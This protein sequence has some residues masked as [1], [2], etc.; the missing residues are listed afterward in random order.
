MHYVIPAKAGIQSIKKS[1]TQWDIAF[2]P[3]LARYAELYD[4]L[5]SG[6]R[7]ND[8]GAW[9][10]VMNYGKINKRNLS[11]L[12]CSPM[13]APQVDHDNTSGEKPRRMVFSVTTRG[14]RNC[15][16]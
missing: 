8:D 14:S 11:L 7:R 3:S 2:A 13:A 5:D 9:R 10:F 4:G 6:L 12:I 16:R 1:P 15:R